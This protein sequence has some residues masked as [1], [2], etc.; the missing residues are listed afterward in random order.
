MS[1]ESTA[2]ESGDHKEQET[3]APAKKD[4]VERTVLRPYPKVVYFYLTWIV[5]LAAG[6][7]C[8][9]YEQPIEGIQSGVVTAEQ[10]SKMLS[11]QLFW[12]YLFMMVF[13]FNLMVVAFQFGRMTTVSIVFIVLSLVFLGLWLGILD[14]VFG[15]L[16]DIHP[17]ADAKFFLFLFTVFTVIY[18]FVFIQ[19]RFNYWVVRRNE[20]L[21][22]HGFLGDVKRYHAQS[23]TIHKEIP[24]IFEF[25][26]LRAGSIIIHLE[27]ED[28]A[29]VLENVVGINR[30]ELEVKAILESYAVRIDHS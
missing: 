10:V 30:K 6:F 18:V 7:A 25:L 9:M 22:K 27:G 19:T 23:V 28:R 1:A 17:R 21:H 3:K 16:K 11:V 4:A 29:V 8:A 5:S 12:T 24:D 20:L 26:L 15:W 2:P 13:A 14:S